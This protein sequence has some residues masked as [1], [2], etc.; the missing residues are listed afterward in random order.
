MKDK[1]IYKVILR[2]KNFK[3]IQLA[4]NLNFEYPFT[5][6]KE[7]IE[8]TSKM[9]VNDFESICKKNTDV[10]VEVLLY[11]SISDTYQNWYSYYGSQKKFVDLTKF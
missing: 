2:D 8:R 3:L 5:N 1:F 11:S 7:L 9:L 10:T 4:N 6:D